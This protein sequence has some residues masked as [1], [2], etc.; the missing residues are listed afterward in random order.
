MQVLHL[1]REAVEYT[2]GSLVTPLVKP[3]GN[4]HVAVL[5]SFGKR[6]GERGGQPG[7]DKRRGVAGGAQESV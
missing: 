7:V 6:L 2:I 4:T 5:Y 3:R 1:A